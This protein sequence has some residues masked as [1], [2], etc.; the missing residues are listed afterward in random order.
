MKFI[1]RSSYD[2]IEVL[3]EGLNIQDN[4]LVAICTTSKKK[5][6]DMPLKDCKELIQTLKSKRLY[7]ITIRGRECI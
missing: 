3:L 5:E 4:K 7:F 6:K 1:R 2:D